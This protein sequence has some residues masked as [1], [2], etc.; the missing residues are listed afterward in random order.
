M[1]Y[2]F[3]SANFLSSLATTVEPF[4]I[5]DKR[6]FTLREVKERP[7]QNSLDYGGLLYELRESEKI[8][9]LEKEFFQEKKAELEKLIAGK[10]LRS[11]VGKAYH[12][13]QEIASLEANQQFFQET[14]FEKFILVDVFNAY[15]NREGKKYEPKNVAEQVPMMRDFVEMLSAGEDSLSRSI[16]QKLLLLK[17]QGYELY[18]ASKGSGQ[19][20]FRGKEYDPRRSLSLQELAA[21]YEQSLKQK[22]EKNLASHSQEFKSKINNLLQQKKELEKLLKLGSIKRHSTKQKSAQE[23]NISFSKQGTDYLIRLTVPPFFIKREEEY[24]PFPEAVLGLELGTRDHQVRI[25]GIPNIYNRPYKHPFVWDNFASGICFGEF[26]FVD[27]FAL[28]FQRYLPCHEETASLIANILR[29]GE[30]ILTSAY[31]NDDLS[32]VKSI[33]RCSASVGKNEN[34]VRRY[35]QTRNIAVRIFDNDRS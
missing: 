14:Y 18:P 2:S 29:Q 11:S 1:D 24:Y 6:L 7:E 21:N 26:S 23:G 27:H 19:L 10:I 31:I 5:L 13:E 4:A 35:A 3:L 9:N 16:P 30:R 20:R 22:I 12:L 25:K 28:D 34:D 17:G 8:I 15:F 33:E 32:P